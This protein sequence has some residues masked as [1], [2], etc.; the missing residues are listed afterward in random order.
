MCGVDRLRLLS[1]FHP[2]IDRGDF[3]EDVGAGTA[4]AVPHARHHEQ[5][6]RIRGRRSDRVVDPLEHDQARVGRDERIGPAVIHQQFS[7]AFEEARQIWIA[8]VQQSL[9]RLHRALHIG[10][11]IDRVVVP[12]RPEDDLPHPFM[13]FAR[14]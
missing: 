11:H 12:V 3:V 7:A 10:R 9:V 1:C 14:R 13:R 5:R 2:P 4:L 6:E 8:A